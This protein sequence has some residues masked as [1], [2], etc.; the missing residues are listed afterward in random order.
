MQRRRTRLQSDG[1]PHTS[2]SHSLPGVGG[3]VS[4]AACSGITG[5][6]SSGGAP[7]T[8][9]RKRCVSSSL[10]NLDRGKPT[11]FWREAGGAEVSAWVGEGVDG[12]V[13]EGEGVVACVGERER[14]RGSGHGGRHGR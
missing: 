1:K 13:G 3:T 8:Q 11:T 4:L 7:S 5:G 6:G 12:R 9:S 10:Q 14:A 2:S